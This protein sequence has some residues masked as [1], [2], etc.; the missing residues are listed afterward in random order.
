MACSVPVDLWLCPAVISLQE[1]ESKGQHHRRI[2]WLIPH[3]PGGA[4]CGTHPRSFW[5][6][7]QRFQRLPQHWIEH[8]APTASWVSLE[9]LISSVLGNCIKG[10]S[11]EQLRAGWQEMEDSIGK[12]CKWASCFLCS[13]L[14]CFLLYMQPNTVLRRIFNILQQ[15]LP[16]AEE[17]SFLLT[18][19]CSLRKSNTAILRRFTL[20]CC[21][22]LSPSFLKRQ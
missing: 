15:C 19:L 13:A 16:C 22:C 20:S 11:Q 3:C 1:E 14:L 12:Q 18:P 10:Q 9:T 17:L 6:E 5:D 2:C 8:E 21:F 7:I 4:L